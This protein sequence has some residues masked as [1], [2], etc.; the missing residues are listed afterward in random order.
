MYAIW[1]D[2]A[3]CEMNHLYLHPERTNNYVVAH[4]VQAAIDF[5]DVLLGLT[6]DTTVH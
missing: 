2:G 3:W 6:P 1:F 4:S 5:I